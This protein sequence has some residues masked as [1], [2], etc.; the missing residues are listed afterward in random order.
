M[1]TS[2][3]MQQAMDQ[4]FIVAF[5]KY[6][7]KKTK[8]TVS[9][10]EY[11]PEQITQLV[12]SRVDTQTDVETL[13]GNYSQAVVKAK[14]TL[15]QS[16]PAY[17]DIKQAVLFTYG[18]NPAVLSEFGLTAKKQA[19][20]KDV[21]TK[22]AAIIQAKATRVAR[23]TMGSRQ[24]Q[25]IKGV[26]APASS[27]VVAAAPSVAPIATASAGSNPVASNGVSVGS[28]VTTLNGTGH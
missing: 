12:Q 10:T 3:P 16:K 14:V 21:A 25:K 11:T 19:G 22:Q 17:D 23:H 4:K 26:V 1:R 6:F 15:A 7:G 13:R 2:K 28:T 20:A 18:R 9:E 8:I 24:K 5:N 27:D